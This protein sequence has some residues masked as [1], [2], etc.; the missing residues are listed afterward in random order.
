MFTIADAGH[1]PHRH[2]L[3]FLRH[4]RLAQG[5]QRLEFGLM[6][7]VIPVPQ[8]MVCNASVAITSLMTTCVS[9]M[10]QQVLLAYAETK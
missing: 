5:V 6:P 8:V 7:R 4:R 3:S 9:P 2:G 1:I 10:A